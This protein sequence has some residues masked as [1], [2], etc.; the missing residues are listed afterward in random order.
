MH[1]NDESPFNLSFGVEAIIPVEIAIPSP[2]VEG[3]NEQ[4]NDKLMRSCLELVEETRK[5]AQIR[6]VVYQ[7][8]VARYYNHRMKERA[9]KEGDLVLRRAEVSDPKNA[10]K[11]APSWEGSYRVIRILCPGVYQLENLDGA[12]IPRT[13]HMQNLRKLYQ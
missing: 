11:L 12:P 3:Y 6:V 10:E 7:Q 1:R 9:L 4:M 8:R 2:R 5:K 13:W